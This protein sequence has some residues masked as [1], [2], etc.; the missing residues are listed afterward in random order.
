MPPWW[1]E[2]EYGGKSSAAILGLEMILWI[3]DQKD[4]WLGP[5]DF[6]CKRKYISILFKPLFFFKKLLLNKAL[7]IIGTNF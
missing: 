5:L 4:K 1:L 2:C 3:T 6:L 7:V